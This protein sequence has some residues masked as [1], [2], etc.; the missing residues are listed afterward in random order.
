MKS[1]TWAA[2]LLLTMAISAQA[3][4]PNK[5]KDYLITISTEFGD[6]ELIL[7]DETPRHKE[8]FVKLVNNKYYNGTTFHRIIDNFMIQGGD[9]Y[10]KDDDPNND[11]IGGPGYT[12]PA[13]FSAGYKHVFGSLAA[14]RQGDNIN[15]K[16]ESSGSQFYIVENRN[17]T[18]FLD[19]QYTVFGQVVKG[20]EVIE[21]IAV[22]PKGPSDR[23]LKNISM[24]LKAELLKKKKITE[25]TGYQFPAAEKKKADK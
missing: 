17:G 20:L 9:P 24:T 7:F 13:E 5:K 3:Q 11:G 22:Q 2:I 8:N 14:A 18:P 1:I 4:K 16:K 6:M 21:K 15:P 19:G 23:P 25:R 12:L 10:S